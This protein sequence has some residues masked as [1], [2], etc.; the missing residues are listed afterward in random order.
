MMHLASAALQLI[1]LF[2]C[3]FC[4]QAMRQLQQAG[5][6]S[7]PGSAA[8][9]AGTNSSIA[10]GQQGNNILPAAAALSSSAVSMAC[11]APLP[12]GNIASTSAA[13]AAGAH[14]RSFDMST[15]EGYKKHR[16]G[17]CTKIFHHFV[18]YDHTH[19]WGSY[20]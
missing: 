12:D 16:C 20:M 3:S 5:D 19:E 13:A 1:I 18:T 15:A 2:V 4:L 6:S 17:C 14:R 7:Q 11:N 10:A 8:A 9:A